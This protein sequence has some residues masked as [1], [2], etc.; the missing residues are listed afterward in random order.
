MIDRAYPTLYSGGLD[1]PSK[2]MRGE[3][4]V[5]AAS[6]VTIA[7][8]QRIY[9]TKQSPKPPARI[10]SS[11]IML[12]DRLWLAIISFVGITPFHPFRR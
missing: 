1:E 7:S 6:Q 10:L 11:L 5:Q 9:I 4:R 2:W 3:D 8:V 12:K